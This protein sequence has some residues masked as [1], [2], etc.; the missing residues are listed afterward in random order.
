MTESLIELA[1]CPRD[2]ESGDHKVSVKLEY[3]PDPRYYASCSCGVEGPTF[4]TEHE[5]GTDWN[6]WHDA[7]E[8]LSKSYTECVKTCTE[9]RKEIARL[10]SLLSGSRVF[11]EKYRDILKE[12]EN[13][14]LEL[15]R[16]GFSDIEEL[17]L[18]VLR[19]H[20]IAGRPN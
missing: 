1:A 5:A 13:A 2:D 10:E 17:E 20:K 14:V 7:E 4:E 15:R 12:L 16:K 11:V 8:G 19:V 3:F 18:F 9:H 6:S